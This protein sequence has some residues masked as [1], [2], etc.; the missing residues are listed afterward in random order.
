MQALKIM[1]VGIAAASLLGSDVARAEAPAKK[2]NSWLI[3]APD[4]VE[5]F[6]RIED[7]FGGFSGAMAITADRFDSAYD[8]IVDGNF[9]LATYHWKKIKDA[10]EA[11]LVRRPSREEN[12]VKHFLSGPYKEA[13]YAFESKDAGASRKA[14]LEAREACKEC[15]KAERVEFMNDQPRFRRTASFPARKPAAR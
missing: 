5:R 12:A 3:D 15:H 9:E 2:T 8:A 10:I 1:V 4:D 7:M 11:G 13:L 6:K 14:F